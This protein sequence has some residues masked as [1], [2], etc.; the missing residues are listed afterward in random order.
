MRELGDA[1]RL[2]HEELGRLVAA[3]GVDR[4]V[5]VGESA[6]PMVDAAAGD[7]SWRGSAEFAGDAEQALAL[8]RGALR[9]GD[10]VLVKA[11]RAAGL[12]G[13]AAALVAQA[14]PTTGMDGG[15]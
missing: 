9:E 12:E 5:A 15:R 13:L 10:V 4:L 8:V 14:L 3:V 7:R 2:E 11:S 6:R 1:T